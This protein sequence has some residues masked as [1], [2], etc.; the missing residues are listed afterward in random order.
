MSP[1]REPRRAWPLGP[2]AGVFIAI[3]VLGVLAF[4]RLYDPERDQLPTAAHLRS[5]AAFFSRAVSPALAWESTEI[6]AGTPPLLLYAA[7][8]AILTVVYAAAAM[9]LSVVA[10]V[11]LGF[12]A[13]SA[14]WA[15][16]PAGGQSRLRTWMGR[17]VAPAIYGSTRLLIAVMRSVHELLWAVL[18]LA[19]IGLSDLAAVIAIAIPFSGTLAKV[20]SEMLDEA[21]RGSANALRGLG[22]AP[23]QVFL[24]GLLPRAIADMSSYAFYRFECALRAS[25]IVGFF[26]FETLG[27]YIENSWSEAQYGQVWT[28]LYTMFV[29][30]I[31]MEWWSSALRTRSAQGVKGLRTVAA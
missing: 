23:A 21:P 24:F 15:G 26:G 3:A 12:L 28:F 1:S 6:P 4:I 2:R 22:A 31:A 10:G 29:L 8:G 20:F 7:R 13:S 9:S 5:L 16:D 18:F 17:T 14:W 11:V 27:L 19:A 25:A 30:V